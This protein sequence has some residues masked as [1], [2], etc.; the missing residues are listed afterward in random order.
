MT[1]YEKYRGKCKEMSEQ[2]VADNPTFRLVRGHYVCPIWGKQ[3]HWWCE[4]IDGKVHDPTAR[5]FPSK[6]MGEYIEYDG[7]VEC[8]E[9]GAHIKEDEAYPMGRFFVCSDICARSLV[10]L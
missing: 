6:G 3:Q 1:D 10:G 7:F 2:L 4:D 9:C 8:E 5:Q